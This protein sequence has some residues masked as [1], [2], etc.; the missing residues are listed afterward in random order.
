VF[1][2]GATEGKNRPYRSLGARTYA[3]QR[4]RMKELVEGKN[5][6]SLKQ[7]RGEVSK[8]E[9]GTRGGK[10]RWGQGCEKKEYLGVQSQKETKFQ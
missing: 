4:M 7:G 6:S 5:D 9:K 8:R 3:F 2:R 1:G 10:R